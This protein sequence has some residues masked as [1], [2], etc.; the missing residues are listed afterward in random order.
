MFG[1]KREL[2]FVRLDAFLTGVNP[3]TVI[4]AFDVIALARIVALR[5]RVSSSTS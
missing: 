3:E 4:E 1:M 2:L 5:R